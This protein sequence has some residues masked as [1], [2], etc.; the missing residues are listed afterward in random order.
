ML[1]LWIIGFI[2]VYVVLALL[3]ERSRA[4]QMPFDGRDGMVS[5]HADGSFNLPADSVSGA[6]LARSASIVDTSR[7]K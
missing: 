3:L 2:V 5:P 7:N 4:D 6:G 1:G